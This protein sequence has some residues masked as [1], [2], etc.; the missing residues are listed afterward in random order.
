MN[1]ERENY[2]MKE[3]RA[4]FPISS[5]LVKMYAKKGQ[6][7]ILAVFQNVWDLHKFGLQIWIQNAKITLW[8]NFGQFFRFHRFWSPSFPV[9]DFKMYGIYINL[10]CRFE[11]RTQKLPYERIFSDFI[12]FG[13]QALA[14][15]QNI[16]D[17]HKFG[18]QIWIQNSKI[19]LWKNFGQFFRF[20]PR[21]GYAKKG[22]FPILAVIQ[23]IWDLHKFGLQIW[24]QNVK[25]YPMKEFWAS[26]H[27]FWSKGPGMQKKAIS[28]LAVF[29][30]IWDLHKFGLQI[31]IQN[32]KITQL[33]Y[34]RISG[35]FS[36]FIDF[37][38]QVRVCK[39][40]SFPIL[41]VFQNIWDLH[42]FGLQIWIQ[43]AKITLWKN[44][45]QFFRFHQFWSSGPRYAK[46]DH[47]SILAVI[48]NIWDL[49]KF[50]L[51]IWIQ[52]AKITLWKNFGQFFRFHQFWS[53]CM[54]KRSFLNI[55]CIS[56]CMGFT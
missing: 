5:I 12:D 39:K 32:A 27:R 8:K 2:P 35:N 33:P 15:F 10:G 55:S 53:S 6:F 11:F 17:L 43:N 25:N 16:W 1:S 51:Q 31:W 49:H 3:F 28:I 52:N 42:K 34:E 4:I 40:R 45:G 13:H 38:H 9:L 54:Q 18:L 56:K 7:L 23:N 50:G 20:H 48:Q 22:H 29:Q 36:D 30:N 21:S 46:K 19:T 41:A 44:F 37:G 14:V 47:F 24:I 26:F